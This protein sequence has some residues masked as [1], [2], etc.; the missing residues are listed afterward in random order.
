MMAANW[1]QNLLITN[2]ELLDPVL[3]FRSVVRALAFVL[4]AILIKTPSLHY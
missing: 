4:A 3:F 2:N 1:L